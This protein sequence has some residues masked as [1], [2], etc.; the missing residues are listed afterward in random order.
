[1]MRNGR[2][3]A[4]ADVANNTFLLDR[5]TGILKKLPGNNQAHLL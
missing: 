5:D 1:M 3:M 2:M 4:L